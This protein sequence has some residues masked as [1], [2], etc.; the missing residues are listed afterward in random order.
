MTTP[1]IPSP[2]LQDRQ[3]AADAPRRRPTRAILAVIGVAA[4]VG[5]ALGAAIGPQQQTVSA[6][7]AGDEALADRI[8]SLP[9]SLDSFRALSVAEIGPDGAVFAGLGDADPSHPGAPTADT[10]FELGSIT[11]TFT[12]AL[13]ADAIERGEV[14]A[15]D[16]LAEHLPDLE[17]TAAGEVTLASLSQHSSGLPGLGATAEAEALSGVLLNENPYATTT[18]EQ[19]IAD[20]AVAP[21]DPDQGSVYSNFAVSLLGTA[22]VEAADADDY[23]VSYTHLTLPTILLV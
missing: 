19:L 5:V 3:S 4:V 21:V 11:K 13:F 1:S 23:A 18:T 7:T 16:Q 6:S 14:S 15:D 9:G 17:G 12:G 20:A 10:V 8:R 22:L 2:D